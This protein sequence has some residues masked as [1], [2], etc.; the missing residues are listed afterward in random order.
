MAT[1]TNLTPIEV[2]KGIFP[3]ADSFDTLS[4]T[5]ESTYLVQYGKFVPFASLVLDST[6]FYSSSSVRADSNSDL[7]N[8]FFGVAPNGTSYTANGSATCTQQGASANFAAVCGFQ[9][10]DYQVDDVQ[11]RGSFRF[12]GTPCD[13]SGF[14]NYQGLRGFFFGLAARVNGTPTG[15]GT[16]ST[17]TT[18]VNAYYFALAGDPTG[19]AGGSGGNSRIRYIL[20]KVVSG[21]GTIVANFN[22]VPTYSPPLTGLFATGN[23]DRVLRFTCRTNGGTVEL[24]GYVTE[25]VA[26]QEI[27]TLVLS[28]DDSSSPITAAGRTGIILSGENAVCPMLVNGTVASR[29]TYR[30]NWWSAGPFSG[31]TVFREN[32]TRL[33][34]RS[35]RSISIS[36][37]GVTHSIGLHSLIQGW[38]GDFWTY[39]PAATTDVYT[40][41]MR[42]DTSNNRILGQPNVNSTSVWAYRPY[43]ALDPKFQD[44]QVSITFENANAGN[45][46]NAGIILF[47][48]PGSSNVDLALGYVPSG[49]LCRVE[50]NNGQFDLVLYRMRGNNF[51]PA[52]LT[53]KTNLAGLALNSAFTLRFSV[54]TLTTP[55]PQDGYVKLRAYIGGVLQTWDIGAGDYNDSGQPVTAGAAVFSVLSDGSVVDKKTSRIRSGNGEGLT[56]ASSTATSSGN[57][58]FDSWAIGAGGAPVDTPENDQ[59]S[60]VVAGENDAASGTLSVPYEF[61]SQESDARL[62]FDHTFESD[63]RYVGVR[64]SRS[65]GRWTIGN[66]AATASEATT[67]KSFW[68][69]HKG[70]EVPFSWTTPAGASITA[71]FVVDSLSVEQVTPSVFRWSVELEEVLSE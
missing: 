67:L 66:E 50:Y 62:A 9:W 46:R 68:D 6:T 49:Y 56:F 71:R 40:N 64:Q 10:R 52:Q 30:C 53:K 43:I 14:I 41:A 37:I 23:V 61:G 17:A 4:T 48:T 24:R 16:T 13:G 29:G 36:S 3:S 2:A 22:P 1:A 47:G 15:A 5:L 45:T 8:G 70:A 21:V 28:Y 18:S 35:G 42:V 25:V 20:V 34:Q 27:E 63:H 33:W 19:A 69:S 12:S 39:N 58:Y 26:G 57:V 59:A 65:R 51:A 32:W 7:H 44:R 11:L 31:S 55:T 38:W 60:I 54:Q